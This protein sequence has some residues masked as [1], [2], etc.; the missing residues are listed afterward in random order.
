MD[1]NTFIFISYSLNND[2]YI[3]YVNNDQNNTQI[4]RKVKELLK[5][6]EKEQNHDT[7][8]HNDYY[9]SMSFRTFVSEFK[10]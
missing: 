1:K 3:S 2:T 4:L 7:I 8:S 6:L 5:K 9:V 10:C